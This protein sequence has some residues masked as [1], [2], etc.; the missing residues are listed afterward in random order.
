MNMQTLV[1][2]VIDTEGLFYRFLK[3]KNNYGAEY[4]TCIENTVY[5]LLDQQTSAN[6]PGMLLGKI[7]SGK[8]RTFLGIMGLAYD[9]EYDLVILLTKGT[10]ALVK[11]T[12][13][14][15]NQEFDGMIARDK[16]GV[17]DIMALPGNLSK[18]EL[19]KKL[20]I[21][22]KKETRNMARLYE[23]YLQAIRL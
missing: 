23:A 2:K 12:I 3:D 14:R 17:Y 18:W 9:N 1:K 7:Q 16:L 20:A 11:Q 6:R 15:I 8:T 10:R 13:S 21:V 4:L 19:N 5:H 22:V